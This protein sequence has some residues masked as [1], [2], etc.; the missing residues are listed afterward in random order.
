[1]GASRL[2][3]A[4]HDWLSMLDQVG[5]SIGQ[6]ISEVDSRATAK[7]KPQKDLEPVVT[8]T[9]NRLDQ[10]LAQLTEQLDQANSEAAEVGAEL[11]AAEEAL[12]GWVD[13][14]SVIAGKLKLTEE[15][16]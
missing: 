1:M 12:R 13:E 2:P 9:F 3:H 6:V 14:V 4:V 16:E 8:G 5:R 15:N 10:R 11:L 7:P